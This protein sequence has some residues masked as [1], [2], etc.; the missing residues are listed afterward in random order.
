MH[1]L[2][3]HLLHSSGRM[4]LRGGC[5]EDGRQGGG[6]GRG[7]VG[8]ENVIIAAMLQIAQTQ[9]AYVS[10]AQLPAPL[11]YLSLH[12]CI[13]HHSPSTCR[14]GL[15][16][17]PSFSRVHSPARPRW[18]LHRYKT[19]NISLTGIIIKENKRSMRDKT[20]RRGM[21]V[22]QGVTHPRAHSPHCVSHP[23]HDSPQEF[24]MIQY[25]PSPLALLVS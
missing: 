11:L 2:M 14:M 18:C 22:P 5:Q 25:R 8:E 24:L 4:Q 20:C 1:A 13:P 3:P 16:H 15:W 10:S 12:P 9:Y 21:I 19:C 7:I 6:L 23:V 17:L